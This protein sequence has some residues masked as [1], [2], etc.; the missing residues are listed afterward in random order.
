MSIACTANGI[1][2]THFCYSVQNSIASPYKFYFRRLYCG[3]TLLMDR[4][5]ELQ[6]TDGNRHLEIIEGEHIKKKPQP[7]SCVGVMPA[8]THALPLTLRIGAIASQHTLV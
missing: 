7:A 5:P 3:P 6:N 1:Y 4:R 8:A 2:D